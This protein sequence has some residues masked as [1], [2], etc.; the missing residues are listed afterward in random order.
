MIFRF[1]LLIFAFATIFLGCDEKQS[2][3]KN[4]KKEK[5]LDLAEIKSR[6]KLIVLAE[7]S[8]ISFFI[9]RGAKMG[10]EYEI[11]KHYAKHLKLPMEVR[12]VYDMDHILDDLM[13]FRGDIVACNLTVTKQRK[14]KVAFTAP[15]MR[16]AQ[17][18]V[19]RKPE[20][21]RQRNPKDY[22]KELIQEPEEL[23]GKT[24]HV[25]KNSSYFERLIN[26]QEELG[27]TIYIEGLRGDILAE[28]IIDWVAD[29]LIDF[30]VTDQNV[31]Q[32]NKRYHPDIDIS[33]ALSVKQNISFAI[34][35]SS[36]DLK[37]DFDVWFDSFQHTTTYKFIIHK[38]LNLG[39]HTSKAK[40]EFASSG[41]GKLSPYDDIIKAVASDASWD[42]RLLSSLI[43]QESK[44]QLDKESWAGA[45]GIMQFMPQTAPIYGVTPEST[46]EEQIRGGMKKLQKNFDDWAAVEDSIQRLKFTLATYNAG[47]GHV[48][49]AQRLAEKHGLKPLVWDANVGIMMLELMKPKYYQDEV[50]R[51]G[52]IRGIETF[53]YVNEIFL[54]Y[55]EYKSAFPD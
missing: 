46:V 28:E 2:F 45:F 12:I 33:V 49:D 13:S 44:F 16:S 18:L 10:L 9:Y 50:V 53:N 27:D 41:G 25:W 17:V 23:I 31:A 35:K 39:T 34:R 52:Y 37:E 1:F 6:G 24:V 29:G 4:K 40:R 8:P 3:E 26:L 38:Y 19:Q 32:I 36:K 7:N 14:E 21:W 5:V 55:S 48:Q 11:L 51:F 30:T 43:F 20:N 54:R 47:L 42:W 15:I 22:Q